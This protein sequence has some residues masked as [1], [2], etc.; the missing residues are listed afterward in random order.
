MTLGF[1]TNI[2]PMRFHLD[3]QQRLL[4]KPDK[5]TPRDVYFRIWGNIKSSFLAKTKRSVLEA[6]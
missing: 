3:I 6:C 2:R 1:P 4:E 5:T